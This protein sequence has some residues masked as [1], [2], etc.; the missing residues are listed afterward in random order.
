MVVKRVLWFFALSLIFSGVARSQAA[1]PN[2]PQP[3]PKI[4]KS[5][6]LLICASVNGRFLPGTLSIAG[7]FSSYGEQI[8]ALE[9]RL[10]TARELERKRLR[11]TIANLLSKSR[12][13][14]K[15]CKRGPD[16]LAGIV[17]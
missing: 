10:K 2:N 12:Q 16:A 13:G 7:A 3:F 4:T 1:P 15:L 5:G 6:E 14:I 11:K 9:L 17:Q 8:A